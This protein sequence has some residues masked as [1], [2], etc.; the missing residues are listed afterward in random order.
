[1]RTSDKRGSKR[2]TGVRDGATKQSSRAELLAAVGELGRDFGAHSV[3]FHTAIAEQL[4][5]N[6]TD[7]KCL[8]LAM[9]A[10][11]PVTAGQLAELTGLTTGAITGVIDRLERAGY[12]SRERD[13]HDR[14]RVIIRPNLELATRDIA[15]LFTSMAHAWGT[16]LARYD[17]EDLALILDFMRRGIEL[18]HAETMKLRSATPA[19][20]E[21]IPIKVREH[22]R[23]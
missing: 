18:A 12:V 17:K 8:D 5:L 3:M 14:R 19:A 7:H 9:R 16:L 22:R 2:A 13:A 1:M 11:G 21:P 15:P 23:T 4:G 10:A 6:V 20:A